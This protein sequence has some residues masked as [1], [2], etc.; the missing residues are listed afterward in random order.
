MKD[1]TVDESANAT[2][3]LVTR[4]IGVLLESGI[5]SAEQAT[6]AFNRAIDDSVKKGDPESVRHLLRRMAGQP[7]D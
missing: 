5:L 7:T 2:A 6:T 1:Y 3:L 4:L